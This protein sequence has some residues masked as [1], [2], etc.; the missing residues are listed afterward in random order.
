MKIPD[1]H[2]WR[3]EHSGTYGDYRA[4]AWPLERVEDELDHITCTLPGTVFRA[5]DGSAL[6]LH[7]DGTYVILVTPPQH[8]DATSR[9]C[10]D[11]AYLIAQPVEDLIENA[12]DMTS[13]DIEE[14]KGFG[15]GWTC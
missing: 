9:A 4:Y 13:G 8:N 5:E 3:R 2:E 6:F 15:S 12:R 7:E 1:F 10:A 11:E 14:S